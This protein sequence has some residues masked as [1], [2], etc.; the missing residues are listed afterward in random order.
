MRVSSPQSY[1]PR[2]AS[3]PPSPNRKKKLPL[4]LCRPELP[5]SLTKTPR[6]RG[7]NEPTATTRRP[8]T[9]R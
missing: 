7:I 4:Q 6:S 8:T 1:L 2:R 5:L 9:V 3:H